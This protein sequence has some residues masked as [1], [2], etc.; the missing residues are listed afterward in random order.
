MLNIRNVNA[1]GFRKETEGKHI[2]MYGAGA[3]A[4]TYLTTICKGMMVDVI[5][6][7]NPSLDG[8]YYTDEGIS[9]PIISINK[10][11]QRAK[12]NPDTILFV[13]PTFIAADIVQELDMI[14]ELDGITCYVGL[15]V[16]ELYEKQDFEFTVGE[17]I[18]PR[19]L[20]YCWV[21]GKEIPDQLKRYMESWSKFCP[22]YEIIRWDEN[23]YDFLKHPYMAGAYKAKKW[24]FVPDYA[25]LDIVYNEGGIYLDTD[26]EIV[27]T[28]DV[29]LQDHAFFSC[30]CNLVN[31]G[32]GF[33]AI[34]K[35][36]FVKELRDR[37]D[38]YDFTNRDGS[39]NLRV[40]HY[41]QNPVFTAK[42]FVLNNT[43][44]KRDG[45]VLYPSEIGDP[46]GP[47]HLYD[48]RTN[49]TRSIHRGSWSW[50]SKEDKEKVNERKEWLLNRISH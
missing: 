50:V 18:I 5:V 33:G 3:V 35:C 6:D 48:S 41:Y 7:K 8:T 9:I 29:L 24:G 25:R 17:Q 20:H 49:R 26:V 15:L 14:E 4:S 22:D 31:P 39:L 27:K 11:I 46:F 32:N 21:G 47:Q 13:T 45:I 44:Q 19:K 42:G 10:L 23:N 34:P 38:A 43:Y 2:I 28:F 16:R 40:C 37:Y 36:S 1:D 12:K 30:S